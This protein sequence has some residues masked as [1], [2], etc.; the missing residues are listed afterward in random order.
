MNGQ[1]IPWPR[2]KGGDVRV[3]RFGIFEMDLRSGELRKAGVLV[4]L[5]PQP[6]RVL[7]FLVLRR[8]EV[9]TREELQQ[10]LWDDGTVVDFPQRLNS[11][12]NQIRTILSDD[13]DVPRYVETLPRRGYRWIGPVEIVATLAIH[14]AAERSPDIPASI[15]IP[16]A[17]RKW[18]GRVHAAVTLAA[19]GVAAYVLV[20]RPAAAPP[21]AWK[22]VT[23]QRG[24]VSAARFA[25]DGEVLY[26]A[27]WGGGPWSF[28]TAPLGSPNPQ[29]LPVEGTHL[30]AVSTGGEVAFLTQSK[31]GPPM[32]SR[33]SLAG[34]PSKDV[35]R[36]VWAADWAADGAEFAVARFIMATGKTQVEWPIGTVIAHVE[37][38]SHLRISPDGKHVA[39]L[40]HPVAGDDRGRVVL[41]DRSGTM[42]A[43]TPEW[44]STE[45]LA[46]SPRGDEVWFTASATARDSVLYAA[47][48]SGRVRPILSG[49]G[50][51]VLH[52]VS[53]DG[54]ALI[55]LSTRR[56]EVQFGRLG[57]P[58]RSLSWLD[59]T[60]VSGLSQDGSLA[61]LNETGAGGGIDYGVYLRRT[62]G[63]PPV[64]VG[65]GRAAGLS[66]DGKWVMTIPIRER[67]R[68][69]LVPTGP[70]ETR[71]LKDQEIVAYENAGFF[72]DGKRILFVGQER[73]R[74]MRLYVR[75]IEGGR[76]RAIAP[77]G[78]KAM[79][80]DAISPDGQF[81]VA[82]CPEHSY[83]L[84]PVEGG[85][86]RPVPGVEGLRPLW[87]DPSGKTLYARNRSFTLPAE[88]YRLDVA[89]GRKEPWKVL[90]PPDSVGVYA[91]GGVTATPDGSAYA[92]DY[93]RRL[94]ELYVVEGLR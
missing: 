79:R 15:A 44:S 86:T 73:G 13:A 27:S 25:P 70:G 40:E 33:A 7:T 72:P 38:P 10:Q 26:S 91:I 84:Y 83:C 29:R 36:G 78:I 77:E 51:L 3:V 89:T 2:P 21:P 34:G 50:W 45:G 8:G 59:M 61:L 19:V 68:I 11:C 16:V 39:L 18:L 49:S 63:S 80:F 32:L 47:S 87:W 17:A 56:Q 4:R 1:P 5:A 6:F 35:D 20:T 88:L 85:E 52:D 67:N 65:T 93:V 62:D 31:E 14:P 46:W 92:Y 53:R 24:T 12:I 43:I 90:S 41:L 23:F 94:S 81:V 74:G 75:D 48:S 71:I 54:R 9:V 55:E 82:R 57:Q 64:R 76:P 37:N 66:P 60:S 42:A 30:V 22:R 69:E 28:Y 58:E